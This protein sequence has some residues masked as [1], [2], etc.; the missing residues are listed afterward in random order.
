MAG[1]RRICCRASDVDTSLQLRRVLC[2]N[3]HNLRSLV[4]LV[5]R[6][7]ILSEDKGLS[8]YTLIKVAKLIFLLIR[9]MQ[10]QNKSLCECES[11][12]FECFSKEDPGPSERPGCCLWKYLSTTSPIIQSFYLP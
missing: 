10:N 4:C 3:P 2:D 11:K 8:V 12:G 9:Q 7:L 6:R 5:S 1:L